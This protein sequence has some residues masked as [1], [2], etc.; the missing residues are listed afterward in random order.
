MLSSHSAGSTGIIP[1]P[2]ACPNLLVSCAHPLSFRVP[3]ARPCVSAPSLPRSLMRGRDVRVRI[4]PD[5]DYFDELQDSLKECTTTIMLLLR[6]KGLDAWSACYIGSL[7][8][9]SYSYCLHFFVR[10]RCRGI[11]CLIC[12]CTNQHWAPCTCPPLR[13]STRLHYLQRE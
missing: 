10:C 11:R 4:L 7:Y 1:A 3:F 6:C 5:A 12:L 9:E 8:L 13:R 2:R